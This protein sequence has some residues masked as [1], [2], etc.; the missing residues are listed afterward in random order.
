MYHRYIFSF[1]NNNNSFPLKSR[2]NGRYK[3]RLTIVQFVGPAALHNGGTHATSRLHILMSRI[4]RN[5]QDVIFQLPTPRSAA[6][7]SSARR[8]I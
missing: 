6:R 7:A 5:N 2:Y 1:H 4:T 8:D 3:Q